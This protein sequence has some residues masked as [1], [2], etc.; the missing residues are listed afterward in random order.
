MPKRPETPQD[1]ES[2]KGI[3]ARLTTCANRL[4][5]IGEMMTA[6]SLE[7][8]NVTHFY[9]LTKGLKGVEDFTRFAEAKVIDELQANDL[10]RLSRPDEAQSTD[11]KR[12]KKRAS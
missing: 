6:R 2:F 3:A 9:A 1:S 5:A 7:V 4:S 10:R 12:P 11:P 8:L